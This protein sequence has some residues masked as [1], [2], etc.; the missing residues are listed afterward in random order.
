MSLTYGF[1]NSHNKDRRYNAL[2]MSS[3]FDG[4]ITDGIFEKVG[5]KLMV[6]KGSG[7]TVNVGSGR[8]WFNHT[9]TL[10]DGSL[11]LT[12][13]EAEVVLNR[14]D[15]VV[16]D[17]NKLTR[18]NDI[19]IV[20]G[21][22]ATDPIAP[23]LINN[24]DTEHFQY[25][26]CDIYVGAGV[27]EITQSNITNRVGIDCPF[28]TG[29]VQSVSVDGLMAQWRA[30]WDEWFDAIRDTLDDDIA[31]NLANRI[32]E[33]E[34]GT[35]KNEDF[36]KYKE[37]FDSPEMH[38][39]I[40]RGKYL[41]NEITEAQLGAI[42]DGSFKDLYVGDYWTIPYTVGEKTVTA[43]WRI[44]DINYWLNR[45][46]TKFTNQHLV[47]IPDDI[48][49]YSSD[50]D[51]LSMDS[52]NSTEYGYANASI[53]TVYF[54]QDIN[55]IIYQIFGDTLLEHRE[56]LTIATQMPDGV[57]PNY[58]YPKSGSWCTV[59]CEVPSE[60]MIFGC[61]IFAA[62]GNGSADVKSHT[63]SNTQLAL[64]RLHP[65][66]ILVPEK[67][68]WLRDI[69]NIIR[70]AFVSRNGEASY[71]NAASLKGVRPVFAIG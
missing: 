68:Y 7:M 25:P 57:H 19:I 14:I 65:E 50:S 46:D 44:A 59:T 4:I 62:V 40:F 69:V 67:E 5:E 48:I 21:T 18:I 36:S 35:V 63:V 22:P 37:L 8:A 55:P 27:T 11:L 45:G 31:T 12:V 26:L 58:G 3:I 70:Y 53:R 39:N 38:R 10:N 17:V 23:T 28:V 34:S 49:Q 64:F 30:R 13:S 71:G 2:Q 41:G 61:N 15:T 24:P 43:N 9:W 33:L 66:Q 29:A 32:L 16:V 1:Y 60:I 42:R 20:K 56:Y 47:I 51:T 52:S 54:R 6:S